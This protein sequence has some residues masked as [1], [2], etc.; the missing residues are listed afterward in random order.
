M[1]VPNSF[2]TRAH[3]GHDVMGRG[4][5]DGIEYRRAELQHIPLSQPVGLLG[6][7]CRF[8]RPSPQPLDNPRRRGF[9]LQRKLHRRSPMHNK[10]REDVPRIEWWIPSREIVQHMH[11]FGIDTSRR[12]ICD[13]SDK[14]S[15][16]RNRRVLP[17]NS[18]QGEQHLQNHR[19]LA[20]HLPYHVHEPVPKHLLRLEILSR[21]ENS[22]SQRHSIGAEVVDDV[23]P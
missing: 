6:M 18:R 17:R 12:Q 22:F 1:I 21:L 9:L 5:H 19:S 4:T 15:G 14:R 23:A 20:A 11:H 8:G 10:E 16:L 13:G 3:V 7:G 2:S